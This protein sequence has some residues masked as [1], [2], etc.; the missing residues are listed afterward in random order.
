MKPTFIAG[1]KQVADLYSQSITYESIAKLAEFID[2]DCRRGHFNLAGLIPSYLSLEE[3]IGKTFGKVRGNRNLELNIDM[4][5]L[6]EKILK[7][8]ESNK[9][10]AR[11]AMSYVYIKPKSY[12]QNPLF[13]PQL[14]VP[15]ENRAI[16]TLNKRDE[17][18]YVGKYE[19]SLEGIVQYNEVITKLRNEDRFLNQYAIRHMFNS[20]KSIHHYY[21]D[22]EFRR[23]ERQID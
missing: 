23:K 11:N 4:E 2:D 1:S 17:Y 14:C 10:E 12:Q 19:T 15:L 7:N 18:M 16:A 22:R 6:G 5:E 9:K 20:S 3:V 8:F 13:F 21:I